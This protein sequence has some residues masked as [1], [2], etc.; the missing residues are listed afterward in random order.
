MFGLRFGA[1]INSAGSIATPA[2]R[3]EEV[4][5]VTRRYTVEYDSVVV[6]RRRSIREPVF[7]KVLHHLSESNL[8][9][10][11]LKPD[12]VLDIRKRQALELEDLLGK[13]GD[14]RAIETKDRQSGTFMR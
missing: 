9:Q 1:T 8:S 13:N 4:V 12:E 2:K 3:P 14:T 11:G 7:A 5:D 6:K 10:L